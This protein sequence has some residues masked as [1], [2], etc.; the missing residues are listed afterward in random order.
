[1]GL[2]QDIQEKYGEVETAAKETLKELPKTTVEDVSKSDLVSSMTSILF[3]SSVGLKKQIGLPLSSL[4]KGQINQATDMLTGLEQSMYELGNFIGLNKDETLQELKNKA[5]TRYKKYKPEDKAMAAMGEFVF[6]AAS[7]APLATLRW[8][9]SGSKFV[10]I[11]KQKEKK[12]KARQEKMLLFIVQQPK[13]FLV[14][15]V[16]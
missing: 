11:F 6:E 4:E 8:F 12:L 5:T 9:N 3:P 13:L 7:A 1:M 16:S 10:Q 14:L 2:L 15:V